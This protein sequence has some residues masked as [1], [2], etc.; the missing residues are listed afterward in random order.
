MKTLAVIF[1]NPDE[2]FTKAATT[3]RVV[4]GEPDPQAFMERS[5]GLRRDGMS[6]I[7]FLDGRGITLQQAT[8][9]FPGYIVPEHGLWSLPMSRDGLR[10][11]ADMVGMPVASFVYYRHQDRV[12]REVLRVEPAVATG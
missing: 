10:K 5:D 4:E 1:W 2:L 7:G 9:A 12:P 11:L 3:L 8:E 6:I